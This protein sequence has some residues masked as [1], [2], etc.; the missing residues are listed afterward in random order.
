MRLLITTFPRARDCFFSVV[1]LSVLAHCGSS[2]LPK[3]T[4]LTRPNVLIITADDLSAI[5]GCY[6][7]P[8]I[9]TP[10][11]DRLAARGM[12][13]E[14]A[15]CQ[16][17]LCN[18]SRT[19]MLSGRR[20][21]TTAVFTNTIDP[22]TSIGDVPFLPEFFKQWGYFTARVG[23]I[24]HGKY[25]DSVNWDVEKSSGDNE[26]QDC[27]FRRDSRFHLPCWEANDHNDEDEPD[28][29]TARQIVKLIEE[30]QGKAFFI[31]AGFIQSHLPFSAPKKYFSLYPPDSIVL[32]EELTRNEKPD[33]KERE[34]IAAYYACI[35]FIDAQVGVIIEALERLNLFDNTIVVFMSDHGLHMG[36]QGWLA[37]KRT[38]FEADTRV[39]LIIAAPAKQANAV[40]SRLVELVDLYPTLTALCG[41]PAP[42]GLEGTSIVPLLDEPDR[43]WKKAAFT[44]KL[45][46]GKPTFSVRTEQF[47]YIASHTGSGKLYDHQSD[48]Q[49][50]TNLV[51]DRRYRETV[52]E[53]K[54]IVLEGWRKAVPA[55]IVVPVI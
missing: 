29:K 20:P 40:S 52:A 9:K 4:T 25:E 50:R 43:P 45:I 12:L 18:P 36:E 54:R 3:A 26:T 55:E 31:A 17:A 47:R 38:L 24:A 37:R 27:P 15:Y 16:Y 22:R 35:S 7:N 1:I 5:L 19:S 39:P 42:E 49:E 46:N 34:A 6:G 11:I 8:I 48:P 23:K 44:S 2:A 21:E 33:R 13:F 10:N 32:T 28:G 41:L 53:M 51:K 14:R 30:H